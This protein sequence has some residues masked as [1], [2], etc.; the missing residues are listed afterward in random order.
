MEKVGYNFQQNLNF[1]WTLARV[2]C[3]FYG[4]INVCFL[5]FVSYPSFENFILNNLRFIFKSN[6]KT[7]RFLSD[8]Y[9]FNYIHFLLYIQI[10][11]TIYIYIS[12]I[13]SQTGIQRFQF[14]SRSFIWAIYMKWNFSSVLYTFKS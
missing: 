10:R 8:K 5:S 13:R 9:A 12:K 4:K 7:K 6:I 14:Q 11:N 3:I 1:S 2:F